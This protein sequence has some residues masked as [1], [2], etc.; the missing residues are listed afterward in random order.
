MYIPEIWVVYDTAYYHPAEPCVS[1]GVHLAT[2][3]LPGEGYPGTIVDYELTI[4]NTGNIDDY[5]R[6]NATSDWTVTL[7]ETVIKGGRLTISGG[8]ATIDGLTVQ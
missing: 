7:P 5:F 1:F 4:T 6:L 8:T 3:Y 2:E